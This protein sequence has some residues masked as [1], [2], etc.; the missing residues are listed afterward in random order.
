MGVRLHNCKEITKAFGTLP[1]NLVEC[2]HFY[3]AE[4]LPQPQVWLWVY[5]EQLR[6]LV[7]SVVLA[8]YHCRYDG[9]TRHVRAIR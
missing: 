3:V 1:L 8:A 4:G 6:A 7:D 2:D 9:H 5:E